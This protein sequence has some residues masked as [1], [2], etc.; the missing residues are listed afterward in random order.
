MDRVSKLADRRCPDCD[1]VQPLYMGREGS[2]RVWMRGGDDVL[3]CPGCGTPLRLTADPQDP[4]GVRGAILNAVVLG[5]GL[6]GT[7]ALVQALGLGT[8][9]LSLMLLLVIGAGFGLGMLWNGRA[10]RRR[11]VERAVQAPG[12][13]G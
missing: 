6:F 5:G 7:L 1:A 10:G 2:K 8:V 12:E 4:K 9:V 11:Q 13:A 3:P